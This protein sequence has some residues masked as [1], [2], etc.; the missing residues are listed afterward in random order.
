MPERLFTPEEAN[1]LLPEIRALIERLVEHRRA[2]R[3]AREQ[4]RA[5]ATTVAGNGGGIDPH[6]LTELDERVAAELRRVARCVNAVHAY[7][8]QVK[9]ADVGLVDF[10]ARRGG[11]LVYLCW[12]LGE[13]EV[14]F[15]HGLDEGFAGRKPLPLE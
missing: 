10:P 14:G 3:E 12:R 15:W 1:A 5:V 9:D 4:R 7:G 6:E 11:D 8:I 13:D 2:L